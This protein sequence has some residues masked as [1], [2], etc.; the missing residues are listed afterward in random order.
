MVPVIDLEEASKINGDFTLRL[1]RNQF[2]LIHLDNILYFDLNCLHLSQQ[3]YQVMGTYLSSQE[4][5][6]LRES[7]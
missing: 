4:V 3:L 6:D 2:E 7:D 5:D 1:F